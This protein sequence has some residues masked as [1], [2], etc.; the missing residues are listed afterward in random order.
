MIVNKYKILLP[1]NDQ[2]LN[3]PIEMNWDFIGRDDSIDDYQETMVK[4]VI[5]GVNDFEIVQFSHKDYITQLNANKTSIQYK[6]NFYDNLL[7][8]TNPGVTIINWNSSYINEGFSVNEIYYYTKSFTKSFFK[9][10]LYDTDDDKTQVLYLTIILPV[11]QGVTQSA[12]LSTLLPNVDIRI[13]NF[14]LDFIGDKEGF[15]IYWL[16][17]RSYINIDEFY[18][19]AKFFNAKTGVY[20]K[21]T[22]TPQSNMPNVFTFKPEDYF[23]YKVKLDYLNKMYE[24]YQTSNPTQRVGVA[25]SPILWYEYI[26]P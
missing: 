5:G 16:R 10:D 22:N 4:E 11:Q 19:S 7:P 13:P 26:N 2:Y 20:V 12:Q 15:F 23:Y 18:M 17:E 3:V 14:V 6:F 1:N 24:V 21:M 8:V 9:L 25:G